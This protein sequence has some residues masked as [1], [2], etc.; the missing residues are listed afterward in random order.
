MVVQRTSLLTHLETR[1]SWK[2][3]DDHGV[4]SSEGRESDKER[5]SKAPALRVR[6]MVSQGDGPSR[7]LV[8]E[9]D[10]VEARGYESD[11]SKPRFENL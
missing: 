1:L 7:M 5:T 11:V 8:C 10:R 4:A 2:V 9:G 3:W 6:E